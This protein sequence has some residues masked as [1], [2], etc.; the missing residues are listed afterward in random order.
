MTEHVGWV[1]KKGDKAFDGYKERYWVARGAVLEYWAPSGTDKGAKGDVVDERELA[2]SYSMKGSI[3]LAEVSEGAPEKSD[4]VS[5]IVRLLRFTFPVLV[6]V[7][8]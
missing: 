7:M 2:G 3:P 8:V 1:K 6:M 4:K 5:E